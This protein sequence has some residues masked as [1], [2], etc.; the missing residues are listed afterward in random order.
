M[1][2]DIWK[3]KVLA[4]LKTRIPS[5]MYEQS[6]PFCNKAFEVVLHRGTRMT[7][8]AGASGLAIHLKA[9]EAHQLMTD[10]L[11]KIFIDTACQ[12][13]ENMK[14][15]LVARYCGGQGSII[16]IHQACSAIPVDVALAPRHEGWILG[17]K[18]GPSHRPSEQWFYWHVGG[19][20]KVSASLFVYKS[21]EE[22][23]ENTRLFHIG[24]APTVEATVFHRFMNVPPNGDG[25]GD[26]ILT[27]ADLEFAMMSGEKNPYRPVRFRSQQ[28]QKPIEP[29]SPDFEVKSISKENHAMSVPSFWC[30]Y[31]K[32][33]AKKAYSGLVPEDMKEG[34]PFRALC[35]FGAFKCT[36]QSYYTDCIFHINSVG[37]D[38]TGTNELK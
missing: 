23:E 16:L 37:V 6:F 34:P 2:A 26:G 15:E 21:Y 27:V 8:D 17:L 20:F 14:S 22:M 11:Y 3:N 33:V 9:N 24:E 5:D 13:V 19:C 25:D 18:N 29:N 38:C 7:G 12:L 10:K 30:Q 31:Q 35:S 4:A 36:S 32:M 28:D 1:F